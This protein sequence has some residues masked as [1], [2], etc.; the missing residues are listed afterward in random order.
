[1]PTIKWAN[2]LNLVTVGT[3]APEDVA[4]HWAVEAKRRRVS[5]SFIITTALIEAFGLPDG[6][7]L[8]NEDEEPT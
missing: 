5:M 2:A 3:K 7:R 1:M 6:A 4:Q 8:L